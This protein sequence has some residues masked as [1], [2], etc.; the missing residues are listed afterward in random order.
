MTNAEAP[1]IVSTKLT[2]T[3]AKNPAGVGLTNPQVSF[4]QAWVLETDGTDQA[5]SLF[6][7][8]PGTSALRPL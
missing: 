2:S 5:L 8:I 4:W 6:K 3:P 1:E 7:G